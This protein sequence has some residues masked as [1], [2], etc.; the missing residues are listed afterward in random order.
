MF[1][2]FV[3]FI[4]IMFLW[5]DACHCNV[6]ISCVLVLG[7][8]LLNDLLEGLGPSPANPKKVENGFKH[9]LCL[10]LNFIDLLKYPLLLTNPLLHA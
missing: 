8:C 4:I 3:E 1:S 2:I 7:T 10:S 5:N 9:V 6:L